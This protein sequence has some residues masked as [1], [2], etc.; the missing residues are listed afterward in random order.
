MD[1]FGEDDEE[2]D[3][4]E[5]TGS[6]AKESFNGLLD[7]IMSIMYVRKTNSENQVIKLLDYFK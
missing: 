5:G 7:F 3:E 6:D 4:D 2:D 1:L